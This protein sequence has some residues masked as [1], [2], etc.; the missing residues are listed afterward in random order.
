MYYEK[1]NLTNRVI[2]TEMF[3]SKLDF[4]IETLFLFYIYVNCSYLPGNTSS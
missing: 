2:I 1:Q 3:S 4:E